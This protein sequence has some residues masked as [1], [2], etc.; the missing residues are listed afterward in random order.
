MSD[1]PPMPDEELDAMLAHLDEWGEIPADQSA[2]LIAELQAAREVLREI[3]QADFDW[4]N[5][6]YEPMIEAVERARSLLPKQGV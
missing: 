6:G 3:V 1:K 2:Q 4:L 5:F